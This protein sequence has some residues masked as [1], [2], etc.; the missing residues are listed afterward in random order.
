MIKNEG[1]LACRLGKFNPITAAEADEI[2]GTTPAA[3]TTPAAQ[4]VA[5]ATRRRRLV[6]GPGQKQTAQGP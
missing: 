2:L 5:A 3:A 1:G 6:G 4:P